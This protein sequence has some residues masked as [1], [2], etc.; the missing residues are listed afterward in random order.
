MNRHWRDEMLDSLH[1]MPGY[2]V[3]VLCPQC[4]VVH[5]LKYGEGGTTEYQRSVHGAIIHLN[6]VHKWSRDQ[7]ADWLESLDID[8]SF[9]ENDGTTSKDAPR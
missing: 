3:W 2:C 9:K 5:A 6:D 4:E 8:L 7:I 1:K